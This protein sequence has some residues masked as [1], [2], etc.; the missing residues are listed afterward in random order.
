MEE[1]YIL[2]KHGKFNSLYI[3]GI[4]VYKRRFYLNMLKEEFELQK[5]EQERAEQKAKSASFR[6]SRK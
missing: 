1:I 4:P 6:R 5:A 2:T 3:E